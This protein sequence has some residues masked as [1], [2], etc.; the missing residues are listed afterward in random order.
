MSKIVMSSIL[1]LLVVFGV[2]DTITYFIIVSG[3]E[4][5]V[6]SIIFVFHPDEK[7]QYMLLSDNR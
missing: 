3:V 5:N 1:H 4:D 7:T 6:V 2:G